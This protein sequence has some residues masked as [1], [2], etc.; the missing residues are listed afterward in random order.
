M[1]DERMVLFESVRGSLGK[2]SSKK[3]SP[4]RQ[5]KAHAVKEGREERK[6]GGC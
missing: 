2:K 1:R 4:V 3:T 5:T 6:G